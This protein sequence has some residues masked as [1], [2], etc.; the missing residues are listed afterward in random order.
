MLIR[1]SM[2]KSCRLFAL[3][4]LA[5]STASQASTQAGS[6]IVL[7]EASP[8]DVVVTRTDF[9]CKYSSGSIEWVEIRD[10]EAAENGHTPHRLHLTVFESTG[11]QIDGDQVRELK[12]AVASF[13]WISRLLVRCAPLEPGIRISMDGMPKDAWA[14]FLL[15][16]TPQRPE[17]ESINLRF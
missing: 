6:D 7:A 4:L 5:A 2:G 10:L 1:R 8:P 15:D 14:D 12:E 13:A 3:A 16:R 11:L 9:V 17:E